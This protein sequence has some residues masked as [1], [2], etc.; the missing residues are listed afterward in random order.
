MRRL[1]AKG[2]SAVTHTAGEQNTQLD[3]IEE[4]DERIAKQKKIAAKLA[5]K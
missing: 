2:L 1:D 3:T 4:A 5:A